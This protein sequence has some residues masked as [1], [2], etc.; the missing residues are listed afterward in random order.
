M[1][2]E[3]ATAYVHLVPSLKG[4]KGTIE[5]ELE[6]AAD[7]GGKKFSG[8]FGKVAVA[9]L[10]AAVGKG[11]IEAGKKA[12]SAV[13]AIAKQSVEAFS[14][15]EQLSGGAELL[16]GDAFDFV[17]DKAVNAYKTVQMS[18]NE[19]LEQVNGFAVGLKTALGGNEQAAAELADRIITAE[20]DIVSA[21]GNSQEAVQNAFN[22]IMKGNFTMLDN[23]QLGITP[24]KEGF[25]EVID[26]VNEWNEAN[27]RAT[28]YQIDNLADCQSALVDYVEMQGLAGYAAGE[29][30]DTIQGSTA[31]M[32]SAWSNV[33]IAMS[34]DNA[35]FGS[36]IDGLVESAS[37]FAS[38]IIPRIQTALSGVGE[39]VKGL[40][41]II[42]TQLP[43][44]IADILP[45]LV[46]AVGTMVDA[47]SE[48]LPDVLPVLVDS[49]V[50]ILLALIPLLIDCGV[51]LFIAIVSDLPTII[52]KIIDAVPEIISG[53][54]G[55]LEE[56]WP[57]I[58]E[59]G[60]NLLLSIKAGLLSAVS[61]LAEIGSNIYN[62][63]K[64]S[65]EEKWENI[66]EIGGN[67]IS[68]IWNGILGAADWLKT[69]V[70]DF[71]TG[72]VDSVK[73]TLGIHSPS[74]V[75]AGIGENMAAGLSVGWDE[76]IDSVNAE[77]SDDVNGLVE[78]ISM[79]GLSMDASISSGADSG[80]VSALFAVGNAI[81]SAVNDKDMSPIV[82]IG[83]RDVYNAWDRGRN[84]VGGK[85]VNA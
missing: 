23:L 19:Y 80:I 54:S 71:F 85:F 56:N 50:D 25:Q 11:T 9:G 70:S 1:A 7:S 34:D 15:F 4:A 83:D 13:S 35:D 81:I 16:Y 10:V 49:A 12:V 65:L 62:K 76:K 84:I 77:I 66:K 24:T 61:K 17:S 53:I 3:I 39:L 8:I 5:N 43:A 51:Q 41:P 33:L 69:Q 2:T 32:K 82:S 6:G 29:A 36:A 55:A 28:E 74:R 73:E 72:L 30:A 44:M 68:G 40:A 38:N 58:K 78:G 27:G 21:T 64:A 60:V 14:D 31:M 26:K 63:I 67:I 20:A 42:T 45:G 18:Q 46:E 22:G 75:F 52:S 37:A 47:V 79:G 59:S 48:I 57:K